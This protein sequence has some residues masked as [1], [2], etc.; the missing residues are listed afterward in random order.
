MIGGYIQTCINMCTAIKFPTH[1]CQAATDFVSFTSNLRQRASA[2]VKLTSNS[3]QAANRFMS[4]YVDLR[5]T[6][7]N[8]TPGAWAWAQGPVPGPGVLQACLCRKSL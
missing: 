8:S 5:Q 7:A 4:S 1:L 3:V 2:S 6:Q